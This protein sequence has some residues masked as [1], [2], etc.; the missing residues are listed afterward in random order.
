MS[1]T[2]WTARTKN[3]LVAALARKGWSRASVRD[4]CDRAY[5]NGFALTTDNTAEM[6][7]IVTFGDAEV[8][9][10]DAEIAAYDEGMDRGMAMV[11]ARDAAR[12]C[13]PDTGVQHA[14]HV[15]ATLDYLTA[16]D[17]EG[18]DGEPATVGD[19]IAEIAALPAF[20]DCGVCLTR[21]PAGRMT[22]F[23]AEYVC[24]DCSPLDLG[25]AACQVDPAYTVTHTNGIT[26]VFRTAGRGRVAGESAVGS[27]RW[28]LEWAAYGTYAPDGS[29]R[30]TYATPGEA[31]AVV[32]HNDGRYT[33]AGETRHL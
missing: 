21:L 26:Q 5:M 33:L 9:A 6:V 14:A 8:D 17:P 3:Q 19:M 25:R 16:N 13:A 18:E 2:T 28:V 20:A 30:G 7:A 24:R 15:L 22:R 32:R 1:K 12:Q 11:R 29:S 23:G 27:F 4:V 10:W 31:Y